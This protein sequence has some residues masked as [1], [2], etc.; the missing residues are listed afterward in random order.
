MGGGPGIAKP[1]W[2]AAGSLQAGDRLRTKGGK[3]VTIL[4]VRYHAGYAHVYT[5][6]VATDHDFFVG[7]AGA[8]VHNQDA[9]PPPP[10]NDPGGVP[11]NTTDLGKA[12][13]QQ[14]TDDKNFDENNYAA[15]KFS[16]GD[17][18]V[19]KSG[20]FGGS[21]TIH[22]E[23]QLI[24]YARKHNLKIDFL[25]SEVSPCAGK[26][27]RLLSDFGVAPGNISHSFD[28]TGDGK[29]LRRAWKAARW[30]RDG[31]K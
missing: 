5:L 7:A 1:E 12:V 27:A 26:C 31:C 3:D 30:Y 22:A 6:T 17:I 2:L 14:R 16:N 11:Y 25:Y 13:F 21:T 4:Q 19:E 15:A 28:H 29:G 9:N 20:K 8:L 18:R 24:T 10:L 23:E